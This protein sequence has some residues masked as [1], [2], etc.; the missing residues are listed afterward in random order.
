MIEMRA[1]ELETEI[2]QGLKNLKNLKPLKST[3][4]DGIIIQDFMI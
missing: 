3:I 2:S 1:N 4:N